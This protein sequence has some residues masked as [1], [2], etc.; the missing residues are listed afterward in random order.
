MK[1]AFIFLA[2]CAISSW[3]D[4][5][6]STDLQSLLNDANSALQAPVNASPAAKP[7]KVAR[8]GK[9]KATSEDAMDDDSS[10][11]PVAAAPI[12]ATPELPPKIVPINSPDLKEILSVDLS[13]KERERSRTFPKSVV[14]LMGGMNWMGDGYSLVRGDDTFQ[15]I[16]GGSLAGAYLEYNPVWPLPLWGPSIAAPSLSLSLGAGYF[17][18]EALMRRTGVQTGDAVYPLTSTPVNFEI[19]PVISLWNRVALQLGYGAGGEFI[20]QNGD[21]E[22][23]TVT[24][25]VWSDTASAALRAYLSDSFEWYLG[26]RIRGLGLG[27][28]PHVHASMLMSGIGFQFTD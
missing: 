13:A 8:K 19:G 27:S 22:T 26:Y 25:L 6:A 4:P 10:S 12:P 3:A 11:P 18:G 23:D 16:S 24:Q 17:R 15:R 7:G 20:H 2:M 1:S 9:K 5:A 28:D 21:G 14:R